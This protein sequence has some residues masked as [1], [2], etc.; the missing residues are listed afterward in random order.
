MLAPYSPQELLAND[1]LADEEVLWSG[2]P[3]PRI[4]FARA[5]LFL[6]PF[7]LLWGGFAL[8]WEATVIAALL[9]GEERSGNGGSLW[10]FAVFGLIFVVAGLYFMVGRFIYKRLKKKKTYYA[11]TNRRVLVLTTLRGRHLNAVFID[12]IPQISKSVNADGVG[13]LRFGNLPWWLAQYDNTGMDLLSPTHGDPPPVFHDIREA[14]SVYELV[15]SLVR[16]SPR[17]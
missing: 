5:D 3:D 17:A 10:F 2:R 15:N 4:T 11:V 6:V 7:S 14:D 13:M 16:E 9:R 8:F 12:R 1:L